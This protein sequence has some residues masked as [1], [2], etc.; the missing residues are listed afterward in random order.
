MQVMDKSKEK[1]RT[2]RREKKIKTKL[3]NKPE[4][5]KVKKSGKSIQKA[6]LQDKPTNDKEKTIVTI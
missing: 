5:H 1:N 3:V 2:H 4:T 6:N